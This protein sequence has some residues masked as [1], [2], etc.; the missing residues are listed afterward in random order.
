MLFFVL[1][2]W[3]KTYATMVVFRFTCVHES[4]VF[5]S[6]W[7]GCEKPKY[8]CGAPQARGYP[9]GTLKVLP[10]RGKTYSR[11]EKIPSVRKSTSRSIDIPCSTVYLLV[12]TST[13]T[14]DTYQNLLV[15]TNSLAGKKMNLQNE[16]TLSLSNSE[17]KIVTSDEEIQ[18]GIY[19]A[20]QPLLH[21]PR[22][23][24]HSFF[25]VL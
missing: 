6:N 24:A 22:R 18:I 13:C 20:G 11:Y 9:I 17:K 14:V 3:Q 23:A 4:V 12:G 1:N 19:R 21:T 2:I 5:F 15:M 10:A 25:Q 8:P 16:H 7:W